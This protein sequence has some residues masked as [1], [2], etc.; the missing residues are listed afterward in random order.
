MCVCSVGI[1]CFVKAAFPLTWL[2]SLLYHF[3]HQTQASGRDMTRLVLWYGVKFEDRGQAYSFLPESKIVPYEDGQ[4]N[5]YCKIPPKIEQ[6]IDK[7]QKLTKTEEQIRRGLIEIEADMGRDKSERAAWMMQ[8][9]EDYEYAEEKAEKKRKKEKLVKASEKESSSTAETLIKR[10]PGRP[11][12]DE[13]VVPIKRKPGRPKKVVMDVSSAEEEEDRVVVEVKKRGP[14]RPKKSDKEKLKKREPPAKKWEIMDGDEESEIETDNDESDKDY[15]DGHVE[16]GADDD[17]DVDGDTHD[18][19]GVEDKASGKKRKSGASLDKKAKKKA[20]VF[21]TEEEKV[22]D[23]RAKAAEYREKKARERAEAQGLEYI[24]GKVGRKSKAAMLEEEQMK[25]TKCEEIFLPMME[26]LSEAKDENNVKVVIKCIKSIMERVEVLTPPFLREYPLGMLVKT[27]RK[28]FEGVYPEVKENCK[29]LTAEMKRVYTEKEPKVPDDFEP[30][31]NKKSSI[32]PKHEPSGENAT[33]ALASST[34]DS[35]KSE[36]FIFK[37]DNVTIKTDKVVIN[38]DKV[39]IASEPSLSKQNSE[40]SLSESL[41]QKLVGASSSECLPDVVKSQHLPPK[42]KRTFSIKGMFDK[43]KLPAET[44]QTVPTSS[45]STSIAAVVPKPKSLPPWVIGPPTKMVEDLCSE[46][47][48]GLEFLFD[49][50]SSAASISKKFDPISV[51]QS[52]ELAVFAETKMRGRHW[53]QYWEKIH[54]VVSLLSPGENKQKPILQ[55]IISGDYQEPSDVVKLTRRDI[56]NSQ[57]TEA[58]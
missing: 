16:S 8:F 55:G 44:L 32:E 57:M 49:A 53:N 48:F 40:M 52:L 1:L 46:R 20:K 43:P 6:K 21:M 37:A 47:A 31:K 45:S 11:K 54:D 7:K 19:D 58:T 41:P 12:K 50:A 38:A 15:H 51:S 22:I 4:R 30:V 24:K 18:S 56:L 10:K 9:K 36:S 2:K 13:T 35:I 39:D 3:N 29:R 33:S 23:R 5:G 25:F 28:S 26:L 17:M 27:V 14:G 34:I 42:Q